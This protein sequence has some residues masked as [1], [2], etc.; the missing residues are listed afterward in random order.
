MNRWSAV[1][2]VAGL[3]LLGACADG[4]P[5][6]ILAPK[7]A[8]EA[9]SAAIIAAPTP[10]LI[11]GNIEGTGAQVCSGLAPAGETWFGFKIDPPVSG[12]TGG[13]DYTLTNGGTVLNWTSDPGFI[14]TAVVIKGGPNT[15]VYYFNPPPATGST[16][17]VSPSNGGSTPQISHFVFCYQVQPVV[18]KTAD[19][20]FDRQYNWDVDKT[21]NAT[22]ITINEGGS[23]NV[24][25]TVTASLDG[26]P[27]DGN[28]AVSGTITVHNPTSVAMTIASVTD[29]IS[30]VG[31][32]TVTCAGVTFPYTLNA[33]A[34][35]NCTYSSALPDGSNRTNTAT[36]DVT[37]AGGMDGVGTAAIVFG[38]SPTNTV[39]AC[40]D[41]TDTYTGAGAAGVLDADLCFNEAPGVYQYTRL[42]SQPNPAVC[43]NFVVNNTAT[44]ITPVGADPQDSHSVNVT[45]ICG[46]GGGGGGPGECT[47]TPGYWGTH[48]H[49]GPAK[50]AES[51]W[52][53]L[54]SDPNP[55]GQGGSYTLFFDSGK[56]W[57]AAFKL[58]ATNYYWQLAAHYMAAK[59]NQ[60]N[61]ATLSA[62]E[63]I[64]L[65]NAEIL[66][67]SYDTHVADLTSQTTQ[68]GQT[69]SQ[70]V[71][72]LTTFNQ[73]GPTGANACD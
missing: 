51:K 31:A 52:E 42:I 64:A 61:G 50:Y 71:D 13:I 53:A 48:S 24:N 35:L 41:V 73:G 55:N 30:G 54:F 45:V 39:N 38:S 63:L 66:L 5:E 44:V 58:S 29:A 60:A 14:V 43:E 19:E 9:I 33:G 18:T 70:I 15:N 47:L 28:W 27:V 57:A 20:T 8:P 3:T 69:A 36:A 4:G 2:S 65:G 7:A 59:L 25:Y 56:T 34:T 26:P 22:N 17:L 10:V 32:V 12:S 72:I 1:A 23:A 49:L 68:G 40:V 67:S 6:K 62:A 46:G 11:I 16:G 37:S 21:A